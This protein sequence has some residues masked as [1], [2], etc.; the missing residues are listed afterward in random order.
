MAVTKIS[1][2]QFESEVLRHDGKTVLV[3]FYAGW[4]PPCRALAPLLDR[5]SDENADRVKV[6]KV[7]ADEDEP[8][9]ERYGVKKIPT[10]IAFR[11]GEE[12]KRAI[13]PQSRRELESL[14]AE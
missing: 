4:C 7:D 10:V 8:L 2:A 5:F 12:V 13:N 14:V 6:V 9:S 3:D 1:E 11:N